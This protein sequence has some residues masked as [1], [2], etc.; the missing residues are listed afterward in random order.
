[1]NFKPKSVNTEIEVGLEFFQKVIKRKSLAFVISDFISTNFKDSL[2]HAAHKHDV[3]S[4]VIKD[5]R[6]MSFPNV[7]LIELQDAETS[8]IM[9]VDT[10]S[11]Y[12]RD[13]FSEIAK[14]DLNETIKIFR[15]SQIDYI[16]IK[17]DESTVDPIIR[18]FKM[19]SKRL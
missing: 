2:L 19:R 10:S 6:E 5:P 1:L 4:V 16:I 7:G 3:I 17:T 14:Q 12:F 18:F 15:A 8:E 11:A 13:K 9:L